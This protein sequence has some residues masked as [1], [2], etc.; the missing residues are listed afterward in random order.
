MSVSRTACK[1]LANRRANANASSPCAFVVYT[2]K[3]V[4]MATSPSN[5]SRRLAWN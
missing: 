4:L 3:G 5:G 1:Y 2:P